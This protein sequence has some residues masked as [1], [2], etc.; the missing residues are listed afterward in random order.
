MGVPG[1]I[2]QGAMVNICNS[3]PHEGGIATKSQSSSHCM[4]PCLK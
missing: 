2:G 1:Y 4:S 3:R